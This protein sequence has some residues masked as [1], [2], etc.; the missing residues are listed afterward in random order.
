VQAS[1]LE[2][3]PPGAPSSSPEGLFTFSGRGGQTWR[4]YPLGAALPHAFSKSEILWG[5]GPSGGS[6]VTVGSAHGLGQ[7]A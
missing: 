7:Y 3:S 1:P 6:C 5:A 4:V 2:V